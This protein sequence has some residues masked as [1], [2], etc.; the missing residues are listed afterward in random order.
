MK[1]GVASVLAIAAFAFVTIGLAASSFSDAAGDTNEAPDV[2]S[3][4]VSESA[5]A[6]VTVSVAVGNHQTLPANSW[7]NLWFDLD[8]NVNTGDEGD[9][10]LVRYLSNGTLEFYRWNGTELATQPLGAITG[11]YSAGVLT[12]TAPR[13]ELNDAAGFG[14]LAVATREQ[15]VEQDAYR[16]ADFAPNTGRSAY[17]GPGPASF[18]D[19]T[20]DQP[21]APDVTAVRVSDAKNGSISF[22]ITTPNYQTLPLETLVLLL[23]DRDGKLTTGGGGADVMVVYQAGEIQILRWSRSRQDFLGDDPPSRVQARNSAGVL[24]IVVHRSELGNTSRFGFAVGA[25]HLGIDNFDAL[26]IAPETLFWQYKVVN[27]AAPQLLAG[28]ST[29]APVRPVAGKIFTITVPV[30]R[31]DTGKKISTGTVACNVRVAGQRVAATGRVSSGSGRCAFRVPGTASHKRITGSM[32][33]RSGGKT[34]TA[35]FAFTVR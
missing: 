16:A 19:P 26:D 12:V 21:A 5:A 23:I 14:I 35:R 18:S 20:G 15:E 11:T 3:V 9:E 28:A 27:K 4:T 6:V 32:V 13:S 24:T 29:G 33:V 30:T 22:A 31:S 34:V 2:T 8:S 10:A 17:L 7:I 25:G 1:C